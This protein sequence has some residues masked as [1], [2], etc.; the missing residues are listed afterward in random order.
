ML[1]YASLK[2]QS[3][4]EVILKNKEKNVKESGFE[5]FKQILLQKVILRTDREADSF[6]IKKSGRICKLNVI[7]KNTSGGEIFLLAQ[8]FSEIQ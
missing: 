6:F 2:Q 3:G 1:H 7:K 5:Y 8:Y 4:N